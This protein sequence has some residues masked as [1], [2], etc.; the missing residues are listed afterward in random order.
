MVEFEESNKID[1]ESVGVRSMLLVVH[2]YT[3]KGTQV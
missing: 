2:C 1:D 3:I